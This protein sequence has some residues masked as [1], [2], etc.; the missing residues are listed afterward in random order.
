M[1]RQ[2]F[3]CAFTY[4]N[5]FSIETTP[6]VSQKSKTRTRNETYIRTLSYKKQEPIVHRRGGLFLESHPACLRTK[7]IVYS[8]I[9]VSAFVDTDDTGYQHASLFLMRG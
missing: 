9:F 6:N 7:L 3:G 5:I 8:Q 4:A 1:K 2:V